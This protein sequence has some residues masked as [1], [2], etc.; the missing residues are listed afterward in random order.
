[1]LDIKKIR[2]D[3]DGVAAKLE[4][5]GVKKE[6][7]QELHELDVRRREL[8]VQSEN[9][10]KER[11]A[12]SDE[13]ALVKREKGDASEKITA[14]KQVS[15]DIKVIDAELADIEE[16]LTTYTTTLPN[17]P[18][19][20]VPV[21]ADEDDNVEIRRHGQTPE[22]SFEPKP[23]WDLG[24]SLGILDWERGGKVTGSR[25]LFYKGAG[26]RL[27]RA[28]YNFMLDEHAKEGYTEM[29]TPYMV[30][31]DSMFGTGQ[32]PKFK[33]DTFEVND[34]RGF[35][36]IPT[37]EVPLT[38]YYRGEIL[39]N[40]ELPIYFTAMSPSFRSE[41]GSAGRDT[42]GLIR[43][44]QFHK[45]EMVK[46][47]RPEE[48]YNEL[49]KMVVNA[50]NI[51]QKLGL[52][53]RVIA[54]STGD[55]GFSAAKTYDLEVWIPAQNTYREISSCSNCEDFQARRAQIRYR[56]EDG[57]VNLLHTLNGSGLAVGRTVA[58]ILE[59]YQN[60]DGSVTIPE[61]LR[62]YMGGLEVIK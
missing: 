33:E 32:Y 39:D 42:R 47:A 59:N 7:L 36:L 12:V 24:E 41:A 61:V 29:I 18:H 6:T 16:K 48:S 49:E 30:N 27:E 34:D 57:K 15:A 58:A 37:A 43:L 40:A 38:N 10:K 11:N 5:R 23:H 51:L 4:T 8:I 35:V 25:F 22:F 3:F 17:L 19:D 20:D 21:G 60:E 53:Y 9:L 54:L 31:Q 28:L 26:A 13:I 44:H 1:M 45:V 14:M 52:A 62:P 46:F 50:E 2:A 56:D 55:M